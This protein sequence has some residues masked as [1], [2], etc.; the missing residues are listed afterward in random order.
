MAKM[1]KDEQIHWQRNT[2]TTAKFLFAIDKAKGTDE[3][4]LM[5]NT[6]AD[7]Y[8]YIERYHKEPAVLSLIYEPDCIKYYFPHLHATEEE[9]ELGKK[10]IKSHVYAEL[11][12]RCRD[13]NILDRLDAQINPQITINFNVL[14][15]L[16][17]TEAKNA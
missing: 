11:L 8:A 13:T 12:S 1:S 4:N 3:Q 5:V 6:A 9:I 2:P 15:K 16:E 14:P 10:I 7:L 17:D